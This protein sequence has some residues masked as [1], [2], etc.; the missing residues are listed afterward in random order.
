MNHGYGGNNEGE[1]E[2]E[3]E[4]SAK[5]SVVYGEAPSDSLN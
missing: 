1:K 3:G 5:G 4:E 2:V